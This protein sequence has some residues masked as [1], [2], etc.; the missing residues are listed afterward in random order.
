VLTSGLDQ[1][2]FPFTSTLTVGQDL[3]AGVKVEVLARTSPASGSVQDLQ[4]VDPTQLG[5]VFPN[6]ERGPFPVM[7]SLTGSLRSF[8]E[9]RPVP[10]PE[11]GVPAA[12]G[13]DDPQEF[14]L[15]VEG[16]PTRMVI[17]GSA[18]LVANNIPFMLNLADWLV[19][20]TSLI[21]IRSKSAELPA[22]P[23]MASSEELA[24]KV[25]NLVTGPILLLLYGAIRQWRR[26]RQGAA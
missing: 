13:K 24:W 15:V 2:L 14:P 26:R 18:D 7:V 19:Q 21:G 8:Y 4:T 3:P 6:E 12:D 23:G 22:L 9:T 10:A 11:A 5:N 17:G 25:F 16:A 20:D 1:M